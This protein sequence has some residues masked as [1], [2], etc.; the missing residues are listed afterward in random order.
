MLFDHEKSV[1]CK[2]YDK[3]Y[4]NGEQLT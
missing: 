2:A 4:D 3:S 1:A